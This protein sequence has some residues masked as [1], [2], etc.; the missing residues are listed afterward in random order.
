MCDEWQRLFLLSSTYL[1]IILLQVCCYLWYNDQNIGNNILPISLI[2]WLQR[3]LS[4]EI[5]FQT[6]LVI[7][8]EILQ[9]PSRRYS[10]YIL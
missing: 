3:W 7:C 6:I 5:S 10:K 1:S 8:K 4:D 9:Q 2:L